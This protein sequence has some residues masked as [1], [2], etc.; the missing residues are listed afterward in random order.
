LESGDAVLKERIISLESS[1]QESQT[2]AALKEEH[3]QSELADCKNRLAEALKQLEDS[4]VESD[5]VH[6]QMDERFNELKNY[7]ASVEGK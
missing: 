1:L 7:S 2:G 5:E 3:L 6:Q 4:R